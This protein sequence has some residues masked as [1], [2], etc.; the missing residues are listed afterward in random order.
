MAVRVS[1]TEAIRAQTNDLFSSDA[2]LLERVERLSVR[3]TFQS[4]VAEVVYDKL[5]RDR[6]QCRRE[7]SPDGY[8]NCSQPPGTVKMTLD[9]VDVQRPEL[10]D[11]HSAP[12]DALLGVG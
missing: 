10:R 8:R 1:P 6:Y 12:C 2:D 3:L 11:A 4:V 7:E 5:G 9:P